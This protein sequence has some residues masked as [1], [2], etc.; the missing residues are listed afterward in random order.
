VN[1][2]TRVNSWIW[3][4]PWPWRIAAYLGLAAVFSV[5]FLYLAYQ[6]VTW[7]APSHEA[8]WRENRVPSLTVFDENGA[9]LAIRG[10]FYGET[11]GL[12]ELPVH[13][14]QAFVA[15][16]DRRFY[17]H[18]AIDPVGLARAMFVNVRAGGLV[19]GGST[20]TQQ[21]A[22]NLFLT[23]DRTIRR[24]L[25]EM[26]LA[27]WLERHL[28]KD[29][30]LTIYMNRIY[31][32]AGTYGIDA[33]ARY[34]FGK[35]AR[36]L[37]LAE[38]AMLAGLPKAPSRYAPTTDLAQAQARA[39]LVIATMLRE[40]FITEEEAQ[41]ARD[42]PAEPIAFENTDGQ[43][44]FVDY[45]INE[46]EALIGET[47][48]NL[49]VTTTLD[50]TL[51]AAGEERLAFRMDRDGESLNAGQAALITLAPDGAIR[52]M[53]GGRNYAE[54]QFNRAVQ[55]QRQPGSAFKPFVY[56][57][58]LER[59]YLPSTIM[60]DEPVEIGNWRP[61]N[62]NGR[63]VGPVPLA[64]ALRQSINTI[65]VQLTDAVGPANVAATAHRLGIQS[66][67]AELP[68]IALGASEVNLLELTSA[69]IPFETGGA[70]YEPYAITEIRAEDGTLL[71]TREP[72][73]PEFVIDPALAGQ[74][75]DM[76]YQVV[77][78]GTGAA[79]DLGR[80]EAAGKTGTTQ[81]WRDA[82]FVGFTA[83]YVTG[84]WVGNDDDSSMDHVAGGSL[85][86]LIWRDY[87]ADVHEGLPMTDLTRS[88]EVV[89]ADA[90]DE[91]RE[92]RNFLYRAAD[93]FQESGRRIAGGRFR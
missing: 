12:D 22:K 44:Y 37:T 11:L 83:N 42:N 47:D 70:R 84:V 60:I 33:A 72:P 9:T 88:G 80:R 6:I 67:L 23:P 8:L 77:E 10:A 56:L 46:I 17:Q 40:G 61:T 41:E 38:A 31:L 54:S 16:E 3:G 21:V 26:V 87:M 52:A 81:E 73:E 27:M 34:Y 90:V 59:G 39:G 24:K 1:L 78:G 65:S 86:A 36:D 91:N 32:G 51:Q 64:D 14:A 35:S 76:L 48:R 43:Q 29:E 68:S 79:A 13:V 89:R 74:M 57:T 28:S 85:P 62:Y 92:L 4:F 58:A 75:T 18:G 63:Y 20:I 2:I 53:V 69:Y 82:W 7:R 66:D 55:A 15:I 71:Y 50:R 93:Q 25:H 30:I 19:Q 49:L 5:A 45:V